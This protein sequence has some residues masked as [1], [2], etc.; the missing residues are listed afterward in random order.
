MKWFWGNYLP[1]E[2]ERKIPTASPL[3]VSIDQL[4]D[5]LRLLSSLMRMK[6]SLV[7]VR[8]IP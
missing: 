3:Q 8:R 6:Y 2:K 1:D 4:K 5:S 7:R